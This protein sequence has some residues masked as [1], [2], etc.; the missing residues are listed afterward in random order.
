LT[1][2]EVS[3]NSTGAR[4]DRLARD[5]PRELDRLDVH[6]LGVV[7]SALRP[8]GVKKIVAKSERDEHARPR[9]EPGLLTLV[10]AELSDERR[11]GR[12]RTGDEEPRASA[13]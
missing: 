12:R 3:R 8:Y 5:Q 9:H 6:D 13:R 1:S 2:F 10:E 11:A 4:L 7:A